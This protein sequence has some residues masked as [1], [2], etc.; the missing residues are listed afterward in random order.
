MRIALDEADRGDLADLC[1]A[2]G[3]E[4]SCNHKTRA[5]DVSIRP[6]RVWLAHV[7]EGGHAP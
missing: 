6:S 3:P 1:G 5:A 7:S 2:L 4:A